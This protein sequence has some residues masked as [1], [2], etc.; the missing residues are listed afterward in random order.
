MGGCYPSSSRC[1]GSGVYLVDLEGGGDQSDA[2]DGEDSQL[3]HEA[4]KMYG[5][6]LLGGAI[7]IVDSD[8]DGKKIGLNGTYSKGSNIKNAITSN[9]IV[10]TADSIGNAPWR[11]G[12][13]YVNDMEGK[14]MKVNLTTQGTFLEYQYL[15]YQLHYLQ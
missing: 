1:S 11:G 13:V 5:T 2:V 3:V 7:K 8:P 15:I 10:I 4:G 14:I 6:E 9:P 12:L